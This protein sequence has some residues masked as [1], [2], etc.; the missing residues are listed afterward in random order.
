[1]LILGV[2]ALSSTMDSVSKFVS[3]LSALILISGDPG[4]GG[5]S[6]SFFAGGSGG[7]CTL[8]CNLVPVY[9]RVPL[10]AFL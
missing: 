5:V 10:V 8:A 2:S 7:L 3:S 1:M 9:E 6:C 4:G